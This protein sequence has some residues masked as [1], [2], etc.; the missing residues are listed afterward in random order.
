MCVYHSH[1]PNEETEP[2]RICLAQIVQQ[3][4]GR[5]GIPSQVCQSLKPVHITTNASYKMSSTQCHVVKQLALNP[6]IPH[7]VRGGGLWRL[8]V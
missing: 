2:P 6:T 7:L 8:F 5:A 4:G 3:V 1:F